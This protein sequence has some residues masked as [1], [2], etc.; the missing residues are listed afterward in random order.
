MYKRDFTLFRF[1]PSEDSPD[2]S[3]ENLAESHGV[4]CGFC[5]PGF[6]MTAYS[7]LAEAEESKV[8]GK[9]CGEDTRKECTMADIEDCFDGNLCRCTGYRPIVDAFKPFASDFDGKVGK[10]CCKKE[11]QAFKVWSRDAK[12]DSCVD[13]KGIS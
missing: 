6:V 7:H 9:E 3:K 4:Q 8:E 11:K 10:L 1:V 13:G 5:S 2:T 12:N